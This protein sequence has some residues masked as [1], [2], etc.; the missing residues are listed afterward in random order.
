VTY[1]NSRGPMVVANSATAIGCV[2]DFEMDP[3]LALQALL[4]GASGP[5]NSVRI[6]WEYPVYFGA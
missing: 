5:L 2:R 1:A 4:D 3:M 6:A